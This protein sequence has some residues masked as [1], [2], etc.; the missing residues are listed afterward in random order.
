MVAQTNHQ[1]TTVLWKLN[2]HGDL[3]INGENL[4]GENPTE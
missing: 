3:F 1:L 4:H 2:S